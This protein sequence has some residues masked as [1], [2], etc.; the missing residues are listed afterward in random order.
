VQ[1]EGAAQ[2]K[3]NERSRHRRRAVAVLVAILGVLT[4]NWQFALSGQVVLILGATAMVGA[5]FL[6]DHVASAVHG[7]GRNDEQ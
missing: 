4:A 5:C 2:V 7:S 3:S 1:A 6:V